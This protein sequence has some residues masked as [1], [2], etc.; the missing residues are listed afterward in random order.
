ML[1]KFNNLGLLPQRPLTGP[2]SFSE[3][4]FVL[5]DVFPAN[6]PSSPPNF[7]NLDDTPDKN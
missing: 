6:N 4:H 5:C 7:N 2:H 1:I 3:F